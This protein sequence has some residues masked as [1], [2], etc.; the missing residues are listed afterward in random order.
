MFNHL[1]NF[2][3]FLSILSHQIFFLTSI[4]HFFLDIVFFCSVSALYEHCTEIDSLDQSPGVSTGMHSGNSP[5]PITYH[6]YT[7][8]QNINFNF[9]HITLRLDAVLMAYSLRYRLDLEICSSF[10]F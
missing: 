3:T 2:F 4:I 1:F 9:L 5:P 10:I 7:Y 6:N 8:N